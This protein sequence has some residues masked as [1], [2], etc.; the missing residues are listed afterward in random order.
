MAVNAFRYLA[1]FVFAV[2]AYALDLRQAVIVAPPGQKA[3]ALLSDEIERRT[4]IRLPISETWPAS[5]AAIF[6]GRDA[7]ARF[8]GRL[9]A[10]APGADGYRIQNLDG[11]ILVVGNDLRGTLYGAGALLR[12]LHMDRDTL[13][14][15]DDLREASAPKYALR[16]HQLG[17]RPKTN[18]YD[19]WTAAMWEQYIRDLVVFGDQCHRA[20]SAAFGRCGRQPALPAAADE[21]DDRD[22]A[23]RE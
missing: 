1:I 14:A 2:Q 17:Y 8:A 13:D 18:S 3:A 7:P 11:N 5:G 20:D 23:H 21:D 10:P 12:R 4:R 15:P 22:V 9:I 6:T 19:G 16:G